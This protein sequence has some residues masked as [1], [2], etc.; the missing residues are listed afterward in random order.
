ML[1]VLQIK[2]SFSLNIL[3]KQTT[4]ATKTP[5][6]YTTAGLLCLVR[7]PERAC[8]AALPWAVS[9]PCPG[10]SALGAL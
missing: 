9:Q 7:W 5:F 1:H 10:D 6:S 8:S 4:A 3:F 2:Q